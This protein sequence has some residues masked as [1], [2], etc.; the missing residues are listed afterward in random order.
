[1]LFAMLLFLYFGCE[2]NNASGDGDATSRDTSTTVDTGTSTAQTSS[3]TADSNTGEPPAGGGCNA[4]A[5][6][7]DGSKQIVV[8]GL[9]RDYIL[10]LP[11]NYD[12]SKSYRLI[13]AWHGLGGTAE[14]IVGN[15]W[16]GYYGMKNLAD[17]M[18]IFVAGQGLPSSADET[19]YKWDNRDGRDVAYTKAIYE[20]MD[21]NFCIDRD[22]VFGIGFSYGGIM[23]NT[24]GCQLGDIFRAV[25]PL[26][27]SGPG[28]WNGS[29]PDNCVGRVAVWLVHGSADT[30][31][32]PIQGERSRDYWLG[33]S[34]CA[35]TSASVDPAPCVLYDDCDE[36]YPVY[37]CLHDG[38]HSLPDWIGEGAWNFFAQF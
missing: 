4:A 2:D 24:I 28:S 26:A 35:G 27:G 11:E 9:S 3:D 1:M 15:E 29:P 23:S 38:E 25:A 36:G 18:T 20:W 12:A 31:V 22:R 6:P 13:F 17:D 21:A 8:D 30:T 33:E 19:D 7:E 32:E 14:Q 37:W 5:W 10:T 16:W 34:H